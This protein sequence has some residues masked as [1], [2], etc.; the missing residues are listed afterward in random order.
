MGIRQTCVLALPAVFASLLAGCAN[1]PPA[2]ST[3]GPQTGLLQSFANQDGGGAEVSLP[4]ANSFADQTPKSSGM[5]SAL[6]RAT[7]KVQDALTIEPKVISAED[8]VRLSDLPSHVGA[9]VYRKAGSLYESRGN[10]EAAIAQYERALEIAPGDMASLISFA[11]LRDRRGEFDE[12][13]SLYQRAIEADPNV[14]VAQND[15][16]LCYAR[17]GDAESA[18]SALRRAI[19]LQPTCKRYRNNIATILVKLGQPD[20]AL[21]H[22]AA[23]HPPDVAHYNAGYLLHRSGHRGSAIQYFT[24]ALQHNPTMAPAR[25][26]LAQLGGPQTRNVAVREAR[27]ASPAGSSRKSRY[28][29]ASGPAGPSSSMRPVMLPA[30]S[31]ANHP[32]APKARARYWL[33]DEASPPVSERE[34]RQAPYWSEVGEDEPLRLPPPVVELGA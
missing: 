2:G 24:Q 15:L 30:N 3:A 28:L 27:G 9:K 12:A 25:Q 26:M 14:A 34:R 10:S 32:E 18:L 8:P 4:T 19:Q 1:K 16:G 6:K 17:S 5:A 21:A 33:G 31:T 22:L 11:R 23:V 20:E 7:R 29:E 13:V